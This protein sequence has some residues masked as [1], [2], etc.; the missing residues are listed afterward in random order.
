[1]FSTRETRIVKEHSCGTD[2]RDQAEAYRSKLEAEIRHEM[3][4]GSSGRTHSLTIADAGL[5]YLDRPG[6]LG[7]G[8]IWRLDQINKIVGERSIAKAADETVE[9]RR[10]RSTAAY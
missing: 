10:H 4:Y 3:L 9:K 5:R 1:L 8:D 7:P 2:R 6:G